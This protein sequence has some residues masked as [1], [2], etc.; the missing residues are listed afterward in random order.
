M[1]LGRGEF[2]AIIGPNGSGRTTLLSCLI[3]LIKPD[4][5]QIRIN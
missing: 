3:G 1:T 5:G 4:S 2:I